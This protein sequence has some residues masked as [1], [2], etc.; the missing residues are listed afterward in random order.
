MQSQEQIASEV[1]ITGEQVRHVIELFAC[2]T[3]RVFFEMESDPYA[4]VLWNSSPMAFF[5]LLGVFSL[6]AHHADGEFHPEEYLLRLHEKET[7]EPFS[8]QMRDWK[9]FEGYKRTQT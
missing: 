2:E 3:H 6:S 8:D 9:R 4:E 7:W 1:G 5:H